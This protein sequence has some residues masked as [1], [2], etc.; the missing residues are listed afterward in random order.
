MTAE[1][2]WSQHFKSNCCVDVHRR[3]V[4]CL[5]VWFVCMPKIWAGGAS[6]CWIPWMMRDVT[7]TLLPCWDTWSKTHS[8]GCGGW[9]RRTQTRLSN[10]ISSHW[11]GTALNWLSRLTTKPICAMCANT[12]RRNYCYQATHHRIQSWQIPLHAWHSRCP[13]YARRLRDIQICGHGHAEAKWGSENGSALVA[14]RTHWRSCI[15]YCW[16]VNIYDTPE[17]ADD[18]E[19]YTAP[20]LAKLMASRDALPVELVADGK[21]KGSEY[22]FQRDHFRFVLDTPSHCHINF[23]KNLCNRIL[24]SVVA[25]LLGLIPMEICLP[26]WW[27]LAIDDCWACCCCTSWSDWSCCCWSSWTGWAGCH[28][29]SWDVVVVEVRHVIVAQVEQI[30]VAQVDQVVV[31][32]IVQVVVA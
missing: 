12:S 9:P 17:K 21:L 26:A 4:I 14:C 27:S 18:F 25:I 15:W 5:Y 22:R 32:Q 2:K 23:L 1:A 31:A 24:G 7:E 29:S 16:N 6:S 11:R 20:M 19:K 8:N 10:R 3:K 28:C 30:V 13:Q